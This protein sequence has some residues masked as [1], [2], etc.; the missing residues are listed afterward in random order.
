MPILL[1]IFLHL[2]IFLNIPKRLTGCSQIEMINAILTM[3]FI[4][5][6]DAELPIKRPNSI[7]EHDEMIFDN[8]VIIKLLSDP[9]LEARIYVM[10][11]EK[12]AVEVELAGKCAVD[13]EGLTVVA[14]GT[15][16]E[17]SVVIVL[18]LLFA[19]VI[20]VIALLGATIL[21]EYFLLVC[22]IDHIVPK[23]QDQVVADEI[24]E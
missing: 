13:E 18:Q 19:L 1:P 9:H 6:F 4:L 2:H 5:M 21:L 7:I 20:R 16:L 3:I 8:D 12:V 23:L 10:I 22:Y 24:M 17:C 15:C 11:W 14:M